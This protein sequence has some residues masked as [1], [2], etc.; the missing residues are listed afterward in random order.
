MAASGYDLLAKRAEQISAHCHVVVVTAVFGRKDKLQQPA[1]VPPASKGCFFAV[2]DPES[3][4][5]LR[6]TA[7][8]D[9]VRAGGLNH[10]VIGAWRL[11]TLPNGSSPFRSPRRSSRVP[12]LLPFQLFPRANYSLW[13]DGKLR[14]LVEPD[15]LVRR[16]LV[17]PHASLA[18]ARNL[19]R[20]HIDEEIG[21]I[22]TTLSGGAVSEGGKRQRPHGA[23]DAAAAKAVEAQWRFY[24]EEQ[25][26]ERTATLSATEGGQVEAPGAGGGNANMNIGAIGEWT[27]QSACAEGAIVLTDIRSAL[28]RC[29]LCAWFNEWYRFGER[30]QLALSYILLRM[31][32][33][34]PTL[35]R[36]SAETTEGSTSD[37]GGNP[38]VGAPA[39]VTHHGVYLWPRE[40]HWNWKAKKGK[41]GGSIERSST[42]R[43]PY[44]R[45]VGHG[46]CANSMDGKRT[47]AG[48]AGR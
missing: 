24:Q 22:R 21:W 8:K 39:T 30:D 7:P 35:E 29:V 5:F 3:A 32:L 20:D 27:R 2:V 42:K 26:T 38:L 11:L 46:G 44:V 40:E 6:K 34:P 36:T 9:V 16:F 1:R 13:I 47:V 15:E 45:Y 4:E 41:G 19:R 43:R 17:Q 37:K 10:N 28:A 18:L 48:C 31:G 23:M 33:T 25:S 12:K 14:L